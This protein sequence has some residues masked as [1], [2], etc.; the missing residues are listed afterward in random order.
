MCHSLCAASRKGKTTPSGII[1][2]NARHH[3]GLP[4]AHCIKH[5]SVSTHTHVLLC[6]SFEFAA[7]QSVCGG[8]TSWQCPRDIS[9]WTGHHTP[10]A[11][12]DS[13]ISTWQLFR[14]HQH[15]GPGVGR[16]SRGLPSDSGSA[17]QPSGVQL[18]SLCAQSKNATTK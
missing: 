4:K 15:L 7:S 2:G 5:G 12:A 9:W 10:F 13:G 18:C 1:Q 8:G 11:R 16:C 3:T 14:Q 6:R 17:G